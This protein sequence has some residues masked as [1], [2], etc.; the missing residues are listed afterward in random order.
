MHG[1]MQKSQKEENCMLDSVYTGVSAGI[2]LP[3]LMLCFSVS[4]LCGIIIALVSHFCSQTSKSFS[5]AIAILPAVVQIVILLVNGNLG[6]GVAVAGA[7]SLVRFRSLPGKATDIVIIFLAMT[8]GLASGMGYIWMALGMSILLSILYALFTRTA[9]LNPS[10]NLRILKI[11]VPEDLD[12][13]SVF[14]E[15]LHEFTNSFR[16]NS[17]RTVNLGSMFQLSYEV[18]LKDVQNEK[19]M[20]DQ[21]R[22]RNGNLAIVCSRQSDSSSEL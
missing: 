17:V 1:R 12:Y 3:Q 19:K 9:F 21:L 16:L 10:D 22:V 4:I 6:V 7:F 18:N 15:V 13:A 2:T 8:V 14:S 11:T 5:I 20:I